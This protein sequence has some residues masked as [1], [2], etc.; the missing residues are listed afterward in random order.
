MCISKIAQDV[1][2]NDVFRGTR[3]NEPS[4]AQCNDVIGI[5]RREIDVVHHHHNGF[6]ELVDKPAQ[7][8]H[9]LDR[10]LH[11]QVVKGPSSRM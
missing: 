2:V 11:V 9:N 1:R 3:M 4:V 10:M 8:L 6:A 5:G 7:Q